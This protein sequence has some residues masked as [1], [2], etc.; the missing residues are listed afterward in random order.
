MTKGRA[1]TRL[2]FLRLTVSFI[3]DCFLIM[4]NLFYT[5]SPRPEKRELFVF[6]VIVMNVFAVFCCF[7]FFLREPTGANVPQLASGKSQR[8]DD[9]SATTIARSAGGLSHQLAS[10]AP[11]SEPVERS[12][13]LHPDHLKLPPPRGHPIFTQAIASGNEEEVDYVE[14]ML[15]PAAWTV[16]PIL[17]C[18]L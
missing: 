16:R 14:A 12:P 7:F 9:C 4:I 8:S 1:T 5:S 15:I 18:S 11:S 3:I 6:I 10:A 17:A 2:V 13:H